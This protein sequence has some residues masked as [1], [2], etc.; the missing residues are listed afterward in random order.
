[1]FE[2]NLATTRIFFSSVDQQGSSKV[3]KI[4]I[5]NKVDRIKGELRKNKKEANLKG[6]HLSIWWFVTYYCLKMTTKI[7]NNSKFSKYVTR[8]V[9]ELELKMAQSMYFVKTGSYGKIS[10]VSGFQ[11]YLQIKINLLFLSFGA[12][13]KNPVCHDWPCMYVLESF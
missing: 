8:D 3:G 7:Q 12:D 9:C 1:M 6:K 10:Q 11:N 5:K 4:Y 2:K 13:S